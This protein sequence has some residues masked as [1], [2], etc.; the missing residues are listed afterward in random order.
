[1]NSTTRHD[2]LWVSPSNDG[3]EDGSHE[4]PFSSLT[5]AID[6]A[7]PGQSVVLKAGNYSGDLT[8]QNSGTMEKP[9][10]IMA[11]PGKTVQCIGACWY[12]Y[13]VTDIICSG[14]TFKGS[15]GMAIAVMGK[16]ERNRFEHLT[17]ADC[18]FAKGNACTMFFGGSGQACNIVESC[19][20]LRFPGAPQT[21]QREENVSIGIMVAEGDSQDGEPN[22]D[23]IVS[24]NRFTGYGYGILLGSQ[25]SSE[26]QYGHQ[27]RNNT[28]ENCRVAGIMTKCGDTLIKGNLV[29]NCARHSISLAAGNGSVVEENRILDCGYGIRVCGPGHTISHNCIVRTRH[30]AITILSGAETRG[31]CAS[32]AIVEHNTLV[33]WGHGSASPRAGIAV[34]PETTCIVRKNLLHGKGKLYEKT[35]ETGPS[36]AKRSFLIQENAVSGGC[37]E[38]DGGIKLPVTFLSLPF[39][40]YTNDSG[41]GARGWM[42]S[43]EVFNETSEMDSDCAASA[44]KGNL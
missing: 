11:E 14:I 20:F 32:N 22:R 26:G 43:P 41:Y 10:R 4:S 1:M 29:K 36:G 34:E 3:L 15:P 24:K 39:D 17:F 38:L 40:N 27:L 33:D 42:V 18:S 44:P 31:L 13:D 16:C 19:D 25:D 9:L 35:N 12:F 28:V 30:D 6:K 37:E 23:C 7:S 8:V 2:L 21:T 5:E